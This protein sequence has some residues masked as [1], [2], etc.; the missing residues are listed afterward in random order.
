MP[1]SSSAT[2]GRW[3]RPTRPSL[4]PELAVLLRARRIEGER[5]VLEPKPRAWAMLL[6]RFRYR[7]RRIS[8]RKHR[9]NQV[10]VCCLVWL[11]H[12]YRSDCLR[13]RCRPA[14]NAQD[15]VTVARPMSAWSGENAKTSSHHVAAG[16]CSGGP[17]AL[18]ARQ[19]R[20]EAAVLEFF[21]VGHGASGEPARRV[22]P[23]E[24]PHHTGLG[25]ASTT[26]ARQPP[27]HP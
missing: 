8:T 6:W 20:L 13:E 2:T 9:G 16:P 26:V 18:D 10:V 27:R 11:E 3:A 24:S 1:S 22:A 15:P 25:R 5:V 19:R 7:S 21:G 17:L 12:D 4:V 14:R 23:V